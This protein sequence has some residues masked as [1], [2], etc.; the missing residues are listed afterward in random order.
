M[1]KSHSD[2]DTTVLAPKGGACT[3]GSYRLSNNID[4][5]CY[6]AELDAVTLLLKTQHTLDTECGKIKVELTGCRFLLACFHSIG[7]AGEKHEQALSSCESCSYYNN[8][9][10]GKLCRRV[11]KQYG[12]YRRILPRSGSKNCSI[13]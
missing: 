4:C 6:P 5:H 3:L 12:R 10:S 8:C 11:Q 13:W 7:D 9:K 1:L 2:K